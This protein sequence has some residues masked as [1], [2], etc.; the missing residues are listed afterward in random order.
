MIVLDT[1][2]VI[3]LIDDAQPAHARV[4][5]TVE[6]DTGPLLLPEVVL[7]EVDYMVATRVGAEAEIRLLRDVAKDAYRLEVLS[8]REIGLAADVV[9]RY[10]DLRI[11]LTDA[12]IVVVAA[13]AGTT[14]ILTLDERHFRVVRPLRGGPSFSIL[15]A[16]A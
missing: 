10:T 6:Q 7:G 4:R 13:R 2:G 1:S 11:G 5:A 14:R 15:P 16:D 9:E 8:G 3:A 12:A